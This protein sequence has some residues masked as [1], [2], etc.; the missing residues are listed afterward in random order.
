MTE[1]T[2]CLKVYQSRKSE[3]KKKGK[4]KD[5]L[6]LDMCGIFL[7]WKRIGICEAILSVGNDNSSVAQWNN[8]N[9]RK[10]FIHPEDVGIFSPKL[11]F[12]LR[13]LNKIM[14]YFFASGI[15]K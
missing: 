13:I 7:K 6:D 14:F 10:W 15:D 8:E 2:W 9:S 1:R 12:Y 11:Y 3:K 4:I 5:W